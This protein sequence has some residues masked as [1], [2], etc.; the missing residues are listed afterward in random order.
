MS[1]IVTRQ[2]GKIQF[3]E[4]AILHFPS[5]LPG[6]EKHTRFLRVERSATAPIIFLQSLDSPDL[7]FAT[8]PVHAID[9]HYRLAI[10]PE[11]QQILSPA[12]ERLCLAILA[13][14]KSGWTANLLAPLVINPKTRVAVQAVR[15]DS[16]YSHQHP[17]GEA[18]PCS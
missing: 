7:C 12:G 2:F 6:F 5:G 10:T 14:G 15:A 4:D 8:A 16:V 3:T 13:P 17:L 18:G 1:E 11:D 9:P